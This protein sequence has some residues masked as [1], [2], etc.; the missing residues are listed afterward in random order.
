MYTPVNPSFTILKWCLRL[1]KLYRY[2]L[3][4]WRK[5]ASLDIQNATSEDPDQTACIRRV[6]WVFA[7]RT[8]PKVRFLTLRFILLY[9]H[10]WFRTVRET[11]WTQCCPFLHERNG[12]REVTW[13]QNNWRFRK[14]NWMLLDAATIVMTSP[15][16]SYP[17]IIRLPLMQPVMWSSLQ[18]TREE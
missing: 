11:F 2:V 7:E 6:I 13:S 18:G 9:L 12:S 10:F 8:C 1:S 14:F 4:M 16:L 15:L 5:F 17:N 3:L